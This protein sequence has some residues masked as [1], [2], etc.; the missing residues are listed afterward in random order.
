MLFPCLA[1]PS[2]PD[3]EKRDLSELQL[4][5]LMG[6]K[7][8]T[9][10][11]ASKFEQKITEAPSAISIVT[12]DDIKRFGYGTLA[13]ILR[14][15]RGFHVTN[16]RN[17]QYVGVRGLSRPGDYNS[18]ILLLID[19]HRTN[20]NIYNQVMLG[21]EFIL[22]LDLVDRIEIIRGP[23]SSLYGSNAFF[24]TINVITKRGRDLG[25]VEASASGGSWES[26]SGRTTF[27]QK[28]GSGLETLISATGYSSRG[29]NFH[30]R[31]FDTPETNN[32]WADRCDKEKA[33]NLFA[34][35]T[36]KSLSFESAY[37]SREKWIPTAAWGT[38]FNNGQDMTIDK[39]GYLDFSYG[40]TVGNGIDVLAR[41]YYD[42]YRYDGYYYLLNDPPPNTMNRD[43]TMGNWWGSEVMVTGR[44]G[45]RQLVTA[46]AAYEDNVRQFQE[47][48]NRSP[49]QTFLHDN[50]SSEILGLYIQDEITLRDNLAL[51][52]GLRYD[53]YTTFGSSTNPRLALV[54]TPGPMTIIKALYGQAFRTPN[55]YE[56]YYTDGDVS[57]K[58]NPSLKPE[59]ITTY[60]LVLE[61]YFQDSLRFTASA[62]YYKVK[63]I[64]T[65][66]TDTDDL[67]VFR[68]T[69]NVTGK[70]L[71]VEVDKTW[72]RDINLRFSQAFQYTK[73][74]TSGRR[75]ANSPA[76][77][78]TLNLTFPLI[79]PKFGGGFETQY[80]SGR[81]KPE[82][83][84]VPS[85]WLANLTL[86]AKDV[87]KNLDLSGS[88]YNLF[89]QTVKYPT[90]NEFRQRELIGDG[91]SFRIKAY[92]RF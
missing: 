17:Y 47:N 43:R 51:S 48:Y 55:V 13:D 77:L 7:V 18:R 67:W 12:S 69:G 44:L 31:E 81:R 5:D 32:G 57:T 26:Y 45:N 22:D 63:D 62:Y 20:D 24:G 29:Q 73:E 19:G 75:A 70:G 8:S 64:I 88:V 2:N 16:D 14:S 34:R 65:Q 84:S 86:L 74:Q 61:K 40:D 52:A 46:G 66:V 11:G 80:V 1:M 68:N 58:S 37:T 49:A 6:L 3:G 35:A 87:V 27:G 42:F 56:L 23:G 85:Y 82:G 50:H 30:F 79:G 39:R 71:E 25:G 9:V 15:Q 33:A 89:D 10:Y 92:Y 90:S 38:L 91:I 53:H 83:G 41:L 28:F 4:E 54:Y 78:S 76:S 21:R 72:P 60:E 59:R 36:F